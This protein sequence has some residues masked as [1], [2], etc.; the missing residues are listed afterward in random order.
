MRIYIG[1]D[2]RGFSLKEQLKTFL[3]S[4]EHEVIDLGAES[5]DKGDD[6]P[7]VAAAVGKKVS[8]N[9]KEN[10]GVLLCG[11]GAGVDIV[12]NKFLGVRSVLAFSKEQVASARRD[13]DVN[14]VS[15][16]A[17]YMI[18]EAAQGIVRAF[19]DTPFLGEERFLRR[20]EKINRIEQSLRGE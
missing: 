14:V 7:D 8:E 11:S 13:D 9:P 20:I 1:A 6:Y 17:D 18:Q 15:I 4:Y 19:L 5:F 2:H 12:A 3:G 16:P 10:R